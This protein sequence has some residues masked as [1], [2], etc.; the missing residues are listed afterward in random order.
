MS[1]LQNS[2]AVLKI[3]LTIVH[4]LESTPLQN[5]LWI[6]YGQI[7]LV[8]IVVDYFSLVLLWA[9]SSKPVQINLSSLT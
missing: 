7:Y 3:P 1:T 9:T 4:I 6:E 5:S 2:I 8:T